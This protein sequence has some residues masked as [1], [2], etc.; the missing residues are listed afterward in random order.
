M[1]TSS[2]TPPTPDT[3]HAL[4]VMGVSGCGKS[5]LAQAIAQDV[6][7]T[8][9]E[10]DSFHPIASQEKMAQGIPLTDQ[11]RAGWLQSLGEALASNHG[12]P[13]V[14]SCSALKKSYRDVLR[15]FKPNL[16]FV[17]LDISPATA[18]ARVSSRAVAEGH[19]FPA[20]LVDNQF[21]T[22]E[23]PTGESGVLTVDATTPLTELVAQVRSWLG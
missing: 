5:S 13:V 1:V 20:T 4:V 12:S 14:L 19:F 7:G 23:V 22:L 11:D 16:R 3:A 10:G 21:A 17:Y 15:G 2:S 9:L 18:L 6:G 8:M